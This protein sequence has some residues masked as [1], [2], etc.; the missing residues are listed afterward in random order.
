M[1]IAHVHSLCLSIGLP[2]RVSIAGAMNLIYTYISEYNYTK[3]LKGISTFVC[4]NNSGYVHIVKSPVIP[5][6]IINSG[7]VHIV[8]SP[9]IPVCTLQLS[10]D[11]LSSC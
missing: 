7:Y 11:H 10:N 8:K 6:C 2:L 3:L 4:I 9:V 5:V 1:E